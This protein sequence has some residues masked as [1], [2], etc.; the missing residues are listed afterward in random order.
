MRSASVTQRLV[1]GP[2]SQISENERYERDERER[3]EEGNQGGSS[4]L[5]SRS[6]ELIC[7]QTTHH[8]LL[9]AFVA[10]Y[11]TTCR[12]ILKTTFLSS[13]HYMLSNG[14]Y[15]K[16]IDHLKSGS[17]MQVNG[18]FHS[19]DKS[20]VLLTIQL[21]PWLSMWTLGVSHI[22]SSYYR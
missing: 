2:G 5:K 10:F 7:L 16:I 19:I 22:E 15:W 17:P 13:D 12:A 6:F 14:H 9:P 3:T 1:G 11:R 4:L 18:A 21:T 8:Y 20:R